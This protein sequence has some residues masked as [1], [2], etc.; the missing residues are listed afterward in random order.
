MQEHEINYFYDYRHE[1]SA[2][3]QSNRCKSNKFMR[4]RACG[5]PVNTLWQSLSV[6]A[7]F[8]LALYPSFM[9]NRRPSDTSESS[10]GKRLMRIATRG[11]RGTEG[12][13][14]HP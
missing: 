2:F 10:S 14:I 6:F 12:Y 3:W 13:S 4:I 7:Q 5:K 1:R 9:D 11:T 8:S